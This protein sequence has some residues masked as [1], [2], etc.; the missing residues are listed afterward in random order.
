[1]A[2]LPRSA[3]AGIVP[4]VA[5]S[6]PRQP[7]AVAQQIRQAREAAVA[8]GHAEG[9]AR[10]LAEGRAR[11]HEEALAA[12]AAAMQAQAAQLQAL[13][14]AFTQ[15]LRDADAAMSG[16]LAELALDLA[17][18]IVGRELAT[19][20]R[21]LTA[22]VQRLL[23]QEP[24]LQ[25]EPRL[26]LHPADAALVGETLGAELEAAGWQVRPDESI[27]RGGCAVHSA[28]GAIDATVE[29]RRSRVEAAFRDAMG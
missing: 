20:P 12:G 17:R 15:A 21:C 29:G 4:S 8:Q 7:D 11:G 16:T 14:A 1:M 25:G 3:A 26:L 5:P 2:A 13:A 24:A 19:D 6:A 9:L 10:G 18:H 23:R 22:L 28:G 27:A